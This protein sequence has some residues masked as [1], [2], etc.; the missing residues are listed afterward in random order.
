[1]TTMIRSQVSAPSALPR[2]RIV[3][4][5]SRAVATALSPYCAIRRWA[6]RW[7]SRSETGVKTN[8]IVM[9]SAAQSCCQLS[10]L[11]VGSGGFTDERM[12]CCQ[13]RAPYKSCQ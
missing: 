8:P 7:M 1:M 5:I 11:S 4:T 12:W 3:S 9:P 13:G 6:A 2:S 10:Q